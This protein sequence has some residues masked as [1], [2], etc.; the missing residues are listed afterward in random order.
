M[1]I[2]TTLS[3]P[4]RTLPGLLVDGEVSK[5]VPMVM[6]I[7]ADVVPWDRVRQISKCSD[8]FIQ[9]VPRVDIQ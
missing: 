6:F 7:D 3:G 1:C 9:Y 8:R 5:G 2:G 4:D